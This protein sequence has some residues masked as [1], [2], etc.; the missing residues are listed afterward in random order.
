[1]AGLVPATPLR[2]ARCL[3]NGIAGTSPAMTVGKVRHDEGRNPVGSL[4]APVHELALYQQKQKVVSIAERDLVEAPAVEQDHDL[5]TSWTG[6]FGPRI[7]RL[8]F[9]ARSTIIFF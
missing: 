1:V 5:L 7:K 2:K 3:K 8:E 9:S 6:R 4:A